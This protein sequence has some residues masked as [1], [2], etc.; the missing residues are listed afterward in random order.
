MQKM[1]NGRYYL[2]IHTHICVCI[3]MHIPQVKNIID[4][5]QNKGQ[6]KDLKSE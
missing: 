3:C 1:Q 6:W 5:R 4:E 2:K